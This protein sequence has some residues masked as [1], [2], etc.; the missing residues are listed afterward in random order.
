MIHDRMQTY[1]RFVF[2]IMLFYF[3][4]WLY[5][6]HFLFQLYH[7]TL[8]NAGI[9]NTYWLFCILRIPQTIIRFPVL[10]DFLLVAVTVFSFLK[11][12]KWSFRILFII[13]ILHII[14]FN[15][16][17]GMHTKS[18]VFLPMLILPFCFDK[19]FD[20]VWQAVRFYFLF[21][22]VIA[23]FFKI[24]NGGLF[25][26]NQLVHILENQHV[27]LAILNPTHFTYQISIWLIQHK[28]IT[29]LCWYGF[30]LMEFVFIAG[31]FTRKFDTILLGILIIFIAST[32]I[33]MRINLADF[34][35]MVP[36]LINIKK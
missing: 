32:F 34:M 19:M 4:Y 2:G 16:Y 22:L 35:L 24:I 3:A 25:H 13:S 31:F 6:G 15:V 5:Q 20:T 10:L 11:N 7:P 14:T 29:N 8:I 18:C 1:H 9:D 23:S 27:D 17:T 33:I 21:V 26:P 12:N 30:F 36:F 28:T